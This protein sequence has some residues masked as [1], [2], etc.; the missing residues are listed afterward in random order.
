M[1]LASFALN[2]DKTTNLMP[3]IFLPAPSEAILPKLNAY[4]V[5]VIVQI[6]PKPSA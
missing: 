3:A 4:Q 2:W 6:K 1:E 5:V